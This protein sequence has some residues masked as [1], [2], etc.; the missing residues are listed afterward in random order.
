MS[1]RSW[2]DL[3]AALHQCALPLLDA[4]WTLTETLRDDSGEEGRSNSVYYGLERDGERIGLEY[5]EEGLLDVYLNE[6]IDIDED[7]ELAGPLFV[8]DLNDEDCRLEFAER[9]WL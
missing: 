4:G 7:A 9:G 6:P 8:L 3:F 1:S 2:E 5:F